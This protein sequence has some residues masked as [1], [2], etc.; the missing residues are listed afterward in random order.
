MPTFGELRKYVLRAS[1]VKN[2]FEF[3]DL[4]PKHR[5]F[6]EKIND[7]EYKRGY[8]EEYLKP[9]SPALCEM[10]LLSKEELQS[11]I[12]EFEKEVRGGKS[13]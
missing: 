12:K 4:S 8:S 13:P 6:W 7:V 5:N 11:W 3:C 2:H 9:E 1:G 10:N